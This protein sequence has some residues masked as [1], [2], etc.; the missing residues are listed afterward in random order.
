M[1]KPIILPEVLREKI[2]RLKKRGQFDQIEDLKRRLPAQLHCL[3]DNAAIINTDQLD[4][5]SIHIHIENNEF[6]RNDNKNKKGII[7]DPKNNINYQTLINDI[8]EIKRIALSIQGSIGLKVGPSISYEGIQEQVKKQLLIDNIRM[9]NSLLDISTYERY[10]EELAFRRFCVFAFYQ[11]EE[12]LN[13]Y[14]DTKYNNNIFTM[15]TDFR[16]LGISINEECTSLTAIPIGTK[17][18]AYCLSTSEGNTMHSLRHVRNME[19]HRCTTVLR[20]YASDIRKLQVQYDALN[21]KNK[22]NEAKKNGKIYNKTSE[23]KEIES[24]LEAIKFLVEPGSNSVIV[25]GLLKRLYNA[26]MLLKK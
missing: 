20:K 9:E 21:L 5:K 11:V 1:A 6:H 16:R 18:Y 25:R 19:E 22:I 13:L 4:D 3:L 17:I 8:T 12:L 26:V 24:R 2:L 23:E 10:G 14:Y 7:E 15:R